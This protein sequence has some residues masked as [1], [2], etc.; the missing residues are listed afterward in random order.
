[1][2]NDRSQASTTPLT[3]APATEEATTPSPGL[4]PR[5]AHTRAQALNRTRP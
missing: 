5:L 3:R 4:E 1:M 2:S